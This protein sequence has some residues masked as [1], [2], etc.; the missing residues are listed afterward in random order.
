MKDLENGVVVSAAAC[1]WGCGWEEHETYCE[2]CGKALIV[3]NE[4]KSYYGDI[5]CEDCFNDDFGD[6]E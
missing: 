2:R 5:L 1:N 3:G 6:E 4:Y